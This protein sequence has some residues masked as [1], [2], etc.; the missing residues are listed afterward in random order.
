MVGSY[1][2]PSRLS[3]SKPQVMGTLGSIYISYCTRVE[4]AGVVS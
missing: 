4:I 2:S 3:I 1:R